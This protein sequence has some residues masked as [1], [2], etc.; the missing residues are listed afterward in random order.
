MT[1][2]D[3]L[4]YRKR[5]YSKTS[6]GKSTVLFRQ[7]LRHLHDEKHLNRMQ[8]R[9]I[10]DFGRRVAVDTHPFHRASYVVSVRQYQRLQSRFLQS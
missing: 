3:F 4:A 10:A 2:A 5:I 6:P 8:Q 1:S 7:S 9:S